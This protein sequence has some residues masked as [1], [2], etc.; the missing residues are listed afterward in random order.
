M[1]RA[2]RPLST[3]VLG[4][5]A[6]TG[7]IRTVELERVEVAS[8]VREQAELGSA[9]NLP[10]SFVAEGSR[11][12]DGDCPVRLRDPGLGARL[13]LQ[14][15]VMLPER[16]S[17]G[18]VYHPFGD[19]TADPPGLYGEEEGEGLRIDCV[20]LRALGVVRLGG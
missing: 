11:G 18:T 1:T 2:L 16:D 6:A 7:C 4:L 12:S 20:R 9:G 5:A 8:E 13:V 14:R 10:P 19:Y 17:T 15:S 3:A